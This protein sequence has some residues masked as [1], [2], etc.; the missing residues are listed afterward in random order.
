MEPRYDIL[1]AGEVQPGNEPADVRSRLA[2]LFKASDE[3]MDRLFSGQLVPIKRDVD[4]PTA[5]RYRT[6][7]HKAGAVPV[8]RKVAVEETP[9]AGPGQQQPGTG[10]EDAAGNSGRGMSLAPVGEELL[11]AGERPATE[12]AEI[13]TSGLQLAN[14]CLEPEPSAEPPPAPDTPDLSHLD[15]AAVGENIPNLRSDETP[16]DP[17]TSGLSMGDVGEEIPTLPDE[18]EPLNPDTSALSVADSGSDILES[19]YRRKDTAKAP[20]TDH[21]SLA[22]ED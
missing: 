4:K 21:L 11:S 6:A 13:D 5:T 20:A 15:M 12:A 7:M 22:E 16:L 19:D 3:T 8:I 17:D 1:F 2:G 14:S 9:T 18:R 10:G